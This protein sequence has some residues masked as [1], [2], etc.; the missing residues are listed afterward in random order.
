LIYLT[1]SQKKTIQGL[2]ARLISRAANIQNVLE[3][4]FE[5]KELSLER[6]HGDGK[7]TARAVIGLRYADNLL[8]RWYFT[9][10]ISKRGKV[11]WEIN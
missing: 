11:Q 1:P 10:V 3:Y 2:E 6:D 8:S 5:L 4:N 9:A 7:I